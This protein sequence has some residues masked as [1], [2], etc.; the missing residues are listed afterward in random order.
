MPVVTFWF[1]STYHDI[2]TVYK[3]IL[4]RKYGICLRSSDPFSYSNLL[5]KMGDY[6]LD[7]QYH[8]SRFLQPSCTLAMMITW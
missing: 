6:L 4:I 5:Y 7:T 3:G 8:R 2:I 1:L